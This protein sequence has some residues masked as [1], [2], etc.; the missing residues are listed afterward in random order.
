[1]ST[2]SLRIFTRDI[3]NEIDPRLYGSF[4]EHL[5]RAVYTGIYEPGHAEADETGL[6]RDV[7]SL[8]RDLDIPIV[9]YPGG[10]FVSGYRWED[11]VGPKELR[12]RRL[13]LAW[14]T[15]ETNQFGL[16]E[17]MSWC[18]I[19]NTAPMMA[20]NLGTRGI[21]EAMDVLEYCNH[22]SGTA[23]SDMR[24]RNG[25]KDPYNIRVWCLGNE[26]DGPWQTGHK[27]AREYGRLAAETARAMRVFDKSLEL[28]VCGSSH[29]AMPT[30]AQWEHEVLEETYDDVDFL[31]QH[32]YLAESAFRGDVDYLASPLVIE[33]QIRE[34]IATCDFVKAKL[35]KR[36]TMMISFDE[37][38]VWDQS[39]KCRNDITPW[40][41]APPQLEQAYTM[42]DALVFGGI[43]LVLMRNSDRVRMA[44]LAQLVNVIA[45]I[46][47][48]PGGPAWRQTIFYPLIHASRFGRGHVLQS[49]LKS[50]TQEHTEWG[51]VNDVDAVVTAEPETGVVTVF[52]LNRSLTEDIPFN[53]QLDDGNWRGFSH[54]ILQH[55]DL[56]AVNSAEN[57]DKV[58]PRENCAPVLGGRAFE[59]TLPRASWNVFRIEPAGR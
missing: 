33:A 10:N 52:A 42:K 3:A 49:F 34:A 40:G 48:Q 23:L 47:T 11:G 5:G 41:I 12:P 19:A 13:D 37:W 54:R 35:R 16:D 53:I 14:R 17:F 6:R 57:P 31:S 50:S 22:P 2:S 28:V 26:M 21:Q 18:R 56:E 44:C 9:R 45:P 25:R 15:V 27:T 4:I 8:I 38:N 51:Q 20:V 36:K 29:R 32:A 43:L 30:F 58:V 59:V 1:M 39:A 55:D 24:I 46:M 7:A